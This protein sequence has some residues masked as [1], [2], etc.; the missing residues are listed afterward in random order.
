MRLTFAELNLA[1]IKRLVQLNEHGVVPLFWEQMHTPILPHEQQQLQVIM[2]RL[3]NF[4]LN[5]M[6]EVTIWSRAIYPLLLLAESYPIQAWA[7]V[8]LRAT[9]P[10]FELEGLA[11]G[12]LGSALAGRLD[13]P[14]LIVVEAKRGLEAQNPQFQL[15]Q[16][17]VGGFE[18][19]KPTFTVRYS[20]EYA[21]RLE[22]PTILNLLKSIVARFAQAEQDLLPVTT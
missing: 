12:V 22:A 16:G 20:R 5:L 14:D 4:Q 11:D 2:G 15:Y 9:Y 19:D 8:L 1:T 6:N 17:I 7:Q 21:E 3:L 13:T 10:G 18:T